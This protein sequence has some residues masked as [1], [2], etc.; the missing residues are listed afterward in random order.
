MFLYPFS[1]LTIPVINWWEHS[2]VIYT[3][4]A[5]PCIAWAGLLLA[6]RKRLRWR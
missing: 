2:W 5:I 4:W 6:R 3:Y 1:S